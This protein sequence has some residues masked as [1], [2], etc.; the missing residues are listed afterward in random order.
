M[1][2]KLLGANE[3][4]PQLDDDLLHSDKNPFQKSFIKTDTQNLSD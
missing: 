4:P 2:D 3:I 1:R